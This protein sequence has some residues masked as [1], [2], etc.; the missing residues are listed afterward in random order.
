MPRPRKP[1]SRPTWRK[2]NPQR[3]G[4]SRYAAP[5]QPSMRSSKPSGVKMLAR[6]KKAVLLIFPEMDQNR[7]ITPAELSSKTGLSLELVV[8]L[9]A[10]YPD[11]EKIQNV[12]ETADREA[13]KKK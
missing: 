8:S 5:R 1:T 13:S 11:R 4:V 7:G 12:V 6:W 3:E 2:F 10:Y 9:M